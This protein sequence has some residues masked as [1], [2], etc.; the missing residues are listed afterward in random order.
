MS[1]RRKHLIRSKKWKHLKC[2][3]GD[4]LP[5]AKVPYNSQTLPLILEQVQ[6]LEDLMVQMR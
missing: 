3:C 2:W 1:L 4:N 5:N 6:C